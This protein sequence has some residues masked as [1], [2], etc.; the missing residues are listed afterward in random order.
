V[1][2]TK[3]I[4][5]ISSQTS[6]AEA[7]FAVELAQLQHEFPSRLQVYQFF[8]QVAKSHENYSDRIDKDTLATLLG[9]AQVK[10]DAADFYV[11]GPEKLKT[12]VVDS[13][14]EWGVAKNK[15][16]TEQFALVQADPVG[17]LYSVVF[18]DE[19]KAE[20]HLQVTENQTILAAAVMSDVP[21][22]HACGS[23]LC[24]CC[25]VKITQGHVATKNVEATAL[26]QQEQ[27]AGYI[28]TCQSMP[29]SDLQIEAL[30]Q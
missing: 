14:F 6:Q 24:G 30:K 27:N 23:G 8:T 11:C 28:L 1:S 29:R 21:L 26:I 5:L 12:M 22:P 4:V 9:K 3:N 2:L 16:A 10:L 19:T 25:K 13:L 18:K 20:H 17:E 7:L 15:V